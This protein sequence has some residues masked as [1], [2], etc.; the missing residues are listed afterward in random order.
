MLNN[1]FL[2][3]SVILQKQKICIQTKLNNYKQKFENT[4]NRKVQI[5]AI[6]YIYNINKF[7]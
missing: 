4:N 6:H 5:V 7:H 1:T 2:R 3:N